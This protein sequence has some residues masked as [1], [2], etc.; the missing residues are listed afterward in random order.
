MNGFPL[1]LQLINSGQEGEAVRFCWILFTG[2]TMADMK[3]DAVALCVL[4]RCSLRL[5]RTLRTEF[6]SRISAAAAK[7]EVAVPVQKSITA[8]ATP[9]A[10]PRRSRTVDL[11]ARVQGFL[12][13]IQLPGRT[14][15]RKHHT[16]TIEPETYKFKLRTGPGRRSR[17]Q[18]SI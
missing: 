4:S 7:V 8:I 10:I 2:L 14:V 16:V 3:M 11:V 1:S 9:P 12:Q 15:V 5:Q 13:S 6:C 17:T 18:A